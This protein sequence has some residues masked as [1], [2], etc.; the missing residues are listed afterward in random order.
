[1]RFA[2]I[3]AFVAVQLAMLPC[4]QAQSDDLAK[5]IQTGVDLIKL[6][7]GT[8][9]ASQKTEVKGNVGGNITLANPK[10]AG[11]AAGASV[12][13]TKEEAQGLV[14]ALKKE[15]DTNALKL[16]EKQIDCM[17]P[18]VDAIFRELFPEKRSQRGD[19][20][21]ALSN[22]HISVKSTVRT[23]PEEGYWKDSVTREVFVSDGVIT[24]VNEEVTFTGRLAD[25][26]REIDLFQY[27]SHITDTSIGRP[28]TVLRVHCLMTHCMAAKYNS[29]GPGYRSW[30]GLIYVKAGVDYKPLKEALERVI[31][32]F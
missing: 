9:L 30:V 7:C 31:A 12:N 11:V 27:L 16:S 23:R 2:F 1:M 21:D 4:G 14:A 19:L 20:R 28:E 13:Y 8:G 26:Q 17:K 6:G 5:R 25:V 29:G 32:F 24:I 3:P 15:L 22:L 10:D 18:Y